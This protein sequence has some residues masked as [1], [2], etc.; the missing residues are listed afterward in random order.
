MGVVCN[1]CSSALQVMHAACACLIATKLLA[2]H[3]CIHRPRVCCDLLLHSHTTDTQTC[4]CLRLERAR[5]LGHAWDGRSMSA[6]KRW[7]CMGMGQAQFS[8]RYVIQTPSFICPN[9]TKA[10]PTEGLLQGYWALL[11]LLGGTGPYCATLLAAGGY[12]MPTD[13]VTP[14]YFCLRTD[15]ASQH[16]IN[17]GLLVHIYLLIACSSA[18][19]CCS[20]CRAPINNDRLRHEH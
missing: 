6:S 9:M 4:V 16:R 10:Y 7:I 17:T 14:S 20:C 3:S 11:D 12:L 5:A 8:A 2:A 1:A 13:A 19:G 18:A 15:L